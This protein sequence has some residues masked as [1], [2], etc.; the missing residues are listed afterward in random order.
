[1]VSRLLGF[2]REVLLVRFLGVGALSD[3]FLVAFRFPNS[4][5]KIFA[6]GALSAAF[7]PAMVKMVKKGDEHQ[8]NSFMTIAFLFFQTFVIV[9]CV[10]VYFYADQVIALTAPGFSPQQLALAGPFLRVLFPLLLF[11]SCNALFSGALQ[12]V[13][14][15]MV[16]A[17]GAPLLNVGFIV[18]LIACL[19]FKLP[20]I[21]LC[22][23]IVLA[24][25]GNFFLHLA[26][27]F[28]HNFS[29]DGINRPALK[30][31]GGVA[32]KF[33]GGLFGVSVMEINLFADQ[34]F[35]SY[36]PAGSVTLLNYGTRFMQIPLGV[37]AIAFSTILL[38]HFS[39]VVLYAPKRLNFYLLEASKFVCWL[40][41]PSAVLLMVTSEKLFSTLLLAGRGTP[42][43]IWQASW[44]L[45]IMS[46]GLV[47]FS[48][49]KI[50]TSAFYALHDTWTPTVAGMIAT[51]VNVAINIISVLYLGDWAMFGI[52][53]STVA[54]GVVLATLSV[55][56]LY[57][58]Y[59]M[60]FYFRAFLGFLLRYIPQL[61]LGIVLL[62]ASHVVLGGI[63]A[64]FGLYEF[65]FVQWGY[66]LLMLPLGGLLGLFLYATKKH[67]NVHLYFAP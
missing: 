65:F 53:A 16:P 8:T 50:F 43:Q 10:L 18:S 39:R 54:S 48:L 41:L 46:V 42:L 57:R 22:Y 26:T 25:V 13:N 45:T 40:M 60:H 51:F 3:A 32:K 11:I 61:I 14:H 17:M 7:V 64:Y 63:F 4:L 15:F 21:V 1:M 2:V 44:I 19:Y 49:N 33:L 56:L 66:W 27:Y 12:S 24:A 20:A 23:G 52:A 58:K 31:F 28:W 30:S 37:A 38:T 36:L 6:E 62:L 29:F 67:F 5:R 9:L 55:V 59:G 47:F 34:Y 35:A